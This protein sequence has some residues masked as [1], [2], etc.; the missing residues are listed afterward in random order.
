[1]ALFSTFNFQIEIENNCSFYPSDL[2]IPHIS[3]KISTKSNYMY[4]IIPLN[5]SYSLA[6]ELQDQENEKLVTSQNK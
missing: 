6:I 2:A 5:F 1:M 3:S 4:S